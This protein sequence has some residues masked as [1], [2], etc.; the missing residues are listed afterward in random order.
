MDAPL[1]ITAAALAA[2]VVELVKYLI[3][4]VILKD[5]E[6]DF[7]PVFYNVGV[8]LVVFLSEL[9]L[10]FAE[11]GPM[12]E[13]SVVFLARWFIGVVIALGT[14]ALTIKPYKEYSASL[15]DQ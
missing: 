7:A 9:L 2:F 6:F 8:P 1:F 3:R 14:Y 4:N 15:R 12:P 13:F 10:G 11:L 5:P